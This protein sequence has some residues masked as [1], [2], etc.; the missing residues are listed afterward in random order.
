ESRM[1]KRTRV[2]ARSIGSRSDTQ[3]ANR[4]P[5]TVAYARAQIVKRWM[6]RKRRGMIACMRGGFRSS[7][8]AVSAAAEVAAGVVD[9]VVVERGGR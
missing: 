7:R 8:V 5:P 3:E 2:V 6:E 4:A 1:C 9:K